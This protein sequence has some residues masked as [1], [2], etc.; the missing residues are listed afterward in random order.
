MNPQSNTQKENVMTRKQHSLTGPGRAILGAL[1]LVVLFAFGAPQAAQASTSANA[2]IF[3]QVEVSYTS[4]SNTLTAQADVSVT[5]ATLAAAPTV[6]VDTTAQTTTAGSTVTYTY[7]V[8]SNSNGPDTYTTAAP[9]SADTNISASIDTTPAAVTLWGGITLSAGAGFI[10]LPGGSTTDLADSDTVELTVGGATHRYTVTITTAG[11]GASDGTP[12]VLAKVSLAPIGGAPAITA[13]NVT[14][15]TQVGQYKT[16]TMDQTAGTPT[17]AGTDGT[18]TTNLTL[19]T[20]AT[21]GADAVVTYT[22]KAADSNQVIT[23][24][25]SPEVTIT[26]TADVANAK[27]GETI[28]YTV[29]VTNT[30]A[31]AAATLVTV[32][33][34]VPAYTSMVVTSGNFATATLNGGTAVDISTAVDDENTD[35][36]AGSLVGSA[37]NFYLGAGQDGTAET[38]GT[39]N[40]SDVVVITYQVTVD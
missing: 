19:T 26:K 30:H 3:N 16:T 33:D 39:L 4:G 28:T 6:Y 25:S 5:V 9:D 12:E 29:T 20:T 35:V 18:H 27:P 40:A 13:L 10:N 2:T 34:A 32:T 23:T 17:T 22:T 21:D 37:I 7:T 31:S 8:R 1:A 14:A 15:G 36:V 38:G 24:V 11:N